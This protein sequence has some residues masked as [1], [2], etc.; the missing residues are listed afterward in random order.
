MKEPSTILFFKR[1]IYEF[2]YNKDDE[3]SQGQLALLYEIPDQQT[4][5]QSR[6]VKF[7]SAPTGSHDIKFDESK[8]KNYYLAM[9]FYEV[10]VGIAQI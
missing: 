5:A 4:V 3:F 9:S 7:I 1:A 10:K 6:N 2:T 8:S